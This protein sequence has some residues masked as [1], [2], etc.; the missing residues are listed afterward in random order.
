LWATQLHQQAPVT[1]WFLLNRFVLLG[2]FRAVRELRRKG[3]CKHGAMRNYRGDGGG[4]AVGADPW[5]CYAA[6]GRCVTKL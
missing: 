3:V 1:G 6:E 2:Y 4:I 5:L